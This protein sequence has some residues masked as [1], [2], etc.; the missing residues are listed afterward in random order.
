MSAPVMEVI[1]STVKKENSFRV[2]TAKQC[3]LGLLK[4]LGYVQQSCGA[5]GHQTMHILIQILPSFLL[6]KFKY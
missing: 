6:Q 1:S 5:F 3:A 2:V 4:D